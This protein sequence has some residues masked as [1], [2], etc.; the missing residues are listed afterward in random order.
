[1]CGTVPKIIDALYGHLNAQQVESLSS[2][3]TMF[4]NDGLKPFAE[5]NSA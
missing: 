4:L 3:W 1:M 5:R 2:G